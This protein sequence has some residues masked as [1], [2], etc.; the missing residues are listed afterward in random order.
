VVFVTH[1][2]DEATKVGDR[3]AVMA[4][5]G[6]LEQYASPAEVLAHPATPFVASFVGDDRG[7]KRLAVVAL[8]EGD[9]RPWPTLPAGRPWSGEGRAPAVVDGD[10]QFLGFAEA[11]GGTAGATARV[12]VGASLRDAL[13]ALLLDGRG[14]VALLDADDVFCGALTVE[15]VLEAAGRPSGG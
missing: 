1:D 7:L 6:R 3:I 9:A 15:D 4:V 5:G 14:A 10:G 8:K 11:G 12:R 2:L 13:A